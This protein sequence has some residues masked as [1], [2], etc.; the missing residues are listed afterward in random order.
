MEN[1]LGQKTYDYLRR[2]LARG[3]LPPGT[4]LVNRSLAKEIG[5]S[6]TPVREAIHRL[7]NEG[8]VEYVRGTGAFIRQPDRHEIAQLYDLRLLFEPYGAREAARHM[9]RYELEG[10]QDICDQWLN[11][12][13]TI[14]ASGRKAANGEE[15]ASFF[16][17]EEA[18]HSQMLQAARNRWLT[19]IAEELHV[20]SV[21]FIPSRLDPGV[22][23]LSVIAWT[24][25]GHARVVRALERR[26]SEQAGELL[27]QHIAR[28]KQLVL[29][30]FPWK[31][32]PGNL[33]G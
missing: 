16:D 30:R 4:Q 21:A 5:V 10:L 26:N 19:K 18:F 28:G 23:N 27:S 32:P 22:M 3:E 29:N 14:R 24:W 1:S 15:A 9:T 6:F 20:M 8:L 31:G 11:L 2:K 7:A 13:K 25:L 12:A 17:L 33:L